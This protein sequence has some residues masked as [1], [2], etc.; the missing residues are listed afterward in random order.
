MGNS[1]KERMA[2]NSRVRVQNTTCKFPNNMLLET[3]NICNHA[4]LICANSKG[5]K[6]KGMIDRH[7]AKKILKEA[8]DLGTRE[9]GFYGMG[10]PLLDKNLDEY[11]AYAKQLGYEYVYITTNGVL[12][13]RERAVALIEAGIDSIKFS[14]NA[15]SAKDY[16]LVHGK[17]EF[18]IVIQNLIDLD[19]LRKKQERK[20][21]LYISYI[22]TRYTASDEN[23]FRLNY[24]KYVDDIVFIDCKS[25]GDM[26]DEIN[27]HLSVRQEY[28]EPFENGICPMIF[29]KL[30]I[31]YEGY[32]SMCC[33]DLQNYLVVADLNE[34][35][36]WE[37]WN[38]HYAQDLRRR[39]LE[40]R[41]EGTRCFNCM[42]NCSA[43][44]EPLRQELA[45]LY[46]KERWNKES[47]IKERIQ[48]WQR[49]FDDGK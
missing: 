10:E 16:Y 5:T 18:D 41:L 11:I 38:N 34:E 43:V 8:Y 1:V 36:L 42:N 24:Q 46:D 44:V 25:A 35:G 14:I 48:M 20:I 40:H 4:C 3:T 30:H 33:D 23:G 17:D 15:A 6:K 22:A 7:F 26:A 12:L 29:N 45:V 28:E 9:V 19:T 32:L 2:E 37:A 47:E 31:T 39:H 13:S 21:S 27:R 49:G